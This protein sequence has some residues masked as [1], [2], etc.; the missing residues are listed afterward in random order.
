MKPSFLTNN[1]TWGFYG[2]IKTN[3]RL[4]DFQAA[5]S[6][7]IAGKM[8]AEAYNAPEAA[9]VKLLDSSTGRHI[10]DQIDDRGLTEVRVEKLLKDWRGQLTRELRD[11]LEELAGPKPGLSALLKQ[12]PA[13][14]HG[15]IRDAYYKAAEGLQA[16]RRALQQADAEAGGSTEFLAEFYLAARADDML[17]RSK[18]GTLV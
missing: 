17:G 18:L 11:I 3:L 7:A 2:T 10:A 6:Y 1:P 14:R 9:V 5:E 13:A 12:I 4:T 15:E 16:L 8:I